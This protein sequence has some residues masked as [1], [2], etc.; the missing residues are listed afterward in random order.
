MPVEPLGRN[1]LKPSRLFLALPS[2]SNLLKMV[3]KRPARCSHRVL[4]S[5]F[6]CHHQLR[7][8]GSTSEYQKQNRFIESI[9]CT[10]QPLGF[11]GPGAL[12][13]QHAR[14]TGLLMC[15][16]LSKGSAVAMITRFDVSGFSG[17][18]RPGEYLRRHYGNHSLS[19]ALFLLAVCFGSLLGFASFVSGWKGNPIVGSNRCS[20][21]QTQ[22]GQWAPDV[23]PY[24]GGHWG[25]RHPASARLVAKATIEALAELLDVDAVPLDDEHGEEK[26][27]FAIIRKRNVLGAQNA[28]RPAPLMP[29]WCCKQMHTVIADEYTGCDLCVNPAPSTVSTGTSH[30]TVRTWH[31]GLPGIPLH[32]GAQNII[33]SDQN[34][35]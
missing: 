33:A 14:K 13:Q 31:W 26:N 17:F 2:W 3:G 32:K 9:L 20:L 29:F 16:P 5:S 25:R 15:P 30:Q 34:S 35:S 21:P 1:I 6:R 7:V 12:F 11:A 27:K 10:A 18:C 23:V 8:L 28:S 19:V 4:A 24:A 22:C